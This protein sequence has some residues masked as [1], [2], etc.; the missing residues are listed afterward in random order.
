MDTKTQLEALIDAKIDCTN[1]DSLRDCE[2]VWLLACLQDKE[3]MLD[4]FHDILCDLPDS[5]V[6]EFGRR[7]AKTHG[8]HEWLQ[9]NAEDTKRVTL[10]DA[11]A[12]SIM[13]DTANVG[14]R[15]TAHLIAEIRKIVKNNMDDWFM[16]CRGYLRDM[17]EGMREDYQEKRRDR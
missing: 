16:D 6:V 8:D 3:F 10:I 7:A 13:I 14:S 11:Y 15:I 2:E 9:E 17:E 5:D 4:N 12:A 1:D